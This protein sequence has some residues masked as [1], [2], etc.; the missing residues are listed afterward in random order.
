MSKN[1]TAAQQLPTMTV[2]EQAEAKMLLYRAEVTI[3][4]LR[5]QIADMAPKIAMIELVERLVFGARGM[6]HSPDTGWEIHK[7]LETLEKRRTSS[8]LGMPGT[9]AQ[10]GQNIPHTISPLDR[11]N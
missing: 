11:V 10:L 6:A 7:F 8:Q 9:D 3:N 2:I 5:A 1:E 4:S